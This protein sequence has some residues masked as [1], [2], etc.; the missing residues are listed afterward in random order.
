M[1]PKR[2]TQR[3][4]NGILMITTWV[5]SLVQN[6]WNKILA[7]GLP[8]LVVVA[9]DTRISKGY[10]IISREASKV[11]QLTDKCFLAT[12]GMYADFI[13]LRKT[14]EARLQAYEYQNERQVRSIYINQGHYRNFSSVVVKDVV[15]KAF[16]SLLHIQFV[17][18]IR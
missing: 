9:G 5:L 10:G 12:S 1:E 17:G 15:R 3:M 2:N 11:V 18:W 16:L 7:V 6:I 14:L 8:G 13:A 4:I